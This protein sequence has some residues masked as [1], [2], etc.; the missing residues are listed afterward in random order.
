MIPNSRYGAYLHFP[1]DGEKLLA[2]YEQ[3]R[4]LATP[5]SER[6]TEKYKTE[7]DYSV[8]G[9]SQMGTDNYANQLME[10]FSK[11]YD[12]PLKELSGQ[13]IELPDHYTLIPHT[14]LGRNH[15]VIFPLTGNTPT[16]FYNDGDLIYSVQYAR[17]TPTLVNSRIN[18]GAQ[19]KERGKINF[20]IGITSMVS[21]KYI[22]DKLTQ[23]QPVPLILHP[24]KTG[25]TSL[26]NAV[27][28]TYGAHVVPVRT[29]LTGSHDMHS[30]AK[31][32]LY[33]DFAVPYDYPAAITVRNP[34]TRMWSMYNHAKQITGYKGTFSKFLLWAYQSKFFNAKPC[35]DWLCENIVD[36]IHYEAYHTDIK[37]VYNIDMTEHPHIYDTGSTSS[38]LTVADN[39]TDDTLNLIN[40]M[41]GPDFANFGY[42]KYTTVECMQ[43]DNNG[44][45]ADE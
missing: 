41:A 27:I 45:C 1:Y 35:S 22:L 11:Y 8:L 36:V 10:Q 17:N 25:G 6:S 14:D 33:K 12:I 18:H 30:S 16:D 38:L 28:D 39:L 3:N 43:K 44:G 23:V 9:L 5:F 34:Y 31:H 2:D 7:S 4:D 13:F 26:R 42:K 32:G 24:P 37:R 29:Q 20:Q 21:Y 19:T 40:S 15:V